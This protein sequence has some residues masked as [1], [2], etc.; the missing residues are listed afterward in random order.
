MGTALAAAAAEVEI[1]AFPFLVVA[2]AVAAVVVGLPLVDN[3]A[4]ALGACS[5]DQAVTWT[6]SFHL[7]LEDHSLVD[8]AAWAPA[9]LV[10]VVHRHHTVSVADY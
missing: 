5:V 8:Q 3:S 9:Q 1:P 6:Y 7:L 4:Q 10:G 2:Q